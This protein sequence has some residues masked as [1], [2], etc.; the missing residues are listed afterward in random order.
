MYSTLV[1]GKWTTM[2]VTLISNMFLPSFQS[3][4]L[5]TGHVHKEGLSLVLKSVKRQ[6][7]EISHI[8]LKKHRNSNPGFFI[9]IRESTCAWRPTAWVARRRQ[10]YT[11]TSNVSVENIHFF[12]RAKMRAWETACCV[13]A[14]WYGVMRGGGGLSARGG[15][16][17]C[18]H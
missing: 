4:L 9:R 8:H 6:V 18:P 5:P 3:G 7:R 10:R 2:Y 16:L 15:G 17:L 14:L 12:V 13:V 11:S 1:H